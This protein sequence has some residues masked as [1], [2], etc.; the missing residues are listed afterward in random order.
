MACALLFTALN[1]TTTF[2]QHDIAPGN[3]SLTTSGTAGPAHTKPIPHV[4]FDG[5]ALEFDFPEV[6][7]GVAEYEEGPT[8][9][10]VLYFP[11]RVKAA[12]DVRGGGP[13][14]VDTDVLRLAYDES[15]VNAIVLSGGS[16]YGLSAVTGVANAIR[17]AMTDPGSPQNVAV[18]PG[19]IVFDLGD[20]RFNTITPDDELGRAAFKSLRT[21]WCPLG[22]RGAGRFVETGAFFG[23]QQHSGQG[24]A[25]RQSGETK[26]L[27]VTVI[28]ADGLIVDRAGQVVRCADSVNGKCSSIADMFSAHLRSLANKKQADAHTPA[29]QGL[30]SNTTIT[31][32]V[33]NRALPFW[34][35]QRLAVEVHT[36]MARGIQPYSMSDDG[37]V[38]F[39]A[40]TAQA[41][42]S[43][44][45]DEELSE[46]GVLASETAWDAILASVPG[47][48]PE[49][50]RTN[51]TL[52]SAA[53]DRI[54]G[55]YAF[56]PDAMAELRRSGAVLE[57]EL[58][59]RT[60]DYLAAGHPVMLSPVTTDEFEL[61]GPRRDRLRIDR[62]IR[63]MVVG[64]TLN[65]GP[66]A[67]QAVRK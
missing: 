48:P 63:G 37:D 18:V 25:F 57:I 13:G 31:A 35:L 47:L 55:H 61:A 32:V 3:Q 28:N 67:V 54:V 43:D 41:K 33:T 38:L 45:S 19:A 52:S 8:G 4:S 14:T 7:I 30:T 15:F 36:S 6:R 21:G 46:L 9:T 29:H 64:I 16:S 24:A 58:T 11:Q 20:R 53:L 56:A 66:W 2:A 27:V 44:I 49:T 12:V 42:P 62:D 34:A 65:P 59:G 1:P 5:A 23:P 39:A 26:V 22:A 10:T 51:V 60:T 50:P 17:D 40:T